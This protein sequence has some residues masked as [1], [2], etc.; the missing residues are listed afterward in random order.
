[1]AATSEAVSLRVHHSFVELPD[2]NYTPRKFDPRSGYGA[3]T[4]RDYAAPLGSPMT[5]RF[6]RRHRLEKRNPSAI[7]SDPVEPVIYYLDP[8]APEPIRSALLEGAAWWNQAFESAGYR[9]AFRAELLP[10]GASQLDIRFRREP[11]A[12]QGL[13]QQDFVHG[14]GNIADP[15]PL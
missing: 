2:D 14:A 9:N 10:E 15:F 6:I 5:R 13:A 4:Y 7:V 3:L 1:M 8:G 12:G 11:A